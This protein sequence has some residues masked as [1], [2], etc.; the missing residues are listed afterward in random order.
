MP[1]LS[2]LPPGDS[3]V[4]IREMHIATM[5]KNIMSHKIDVPRKLL[6]LL[7]VIT[8]NAASDDDYLEVDE[9][10]LTPQ[11]KLEDHICMLNAILGDCG[12]PLMDP[13]NAYDW[14]VLY[15]LTA[16]DQSMSEQMERVI[17]I[18]FSNLSCE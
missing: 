8:E 9:D 10:Y 18:M 6:L 17:E 16:S 7:Y 11:D 4:I 1:Y 5:L 14:L 13:H 12:L 2:K 3:N 15:S